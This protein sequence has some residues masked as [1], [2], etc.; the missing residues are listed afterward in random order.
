MGIGEL[1]DA[2]RMASTSYKLNFQTARKNE[3]ICERTLK[4]EELNKFRKVSR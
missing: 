4:A 3:V 1:V 2:N